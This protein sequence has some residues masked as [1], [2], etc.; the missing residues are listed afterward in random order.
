MP[1][2]RHSPFIATLL[3]AATTVL[4]AP[5][6][7]AAQQRAPEASLPV[8]P[9]PLDP[10]IY[11]IIDA[12]S[13]QRLEADIRRLA[14]FGTRS[15]YSDTLSET[16]GI[17]AA[18]RW[19]KAEFDRISAECGGCLEVRYVSHTQTQGAPQPTEIVNVIAIQRGTTHPNRYV[20]MSGDIDSRA[21]DGRDGE[22]DAPGANDNA[23]GM[24]GAIEAARLLSKYQF[25]SSIVYAGLSGEE[26]GLWGGRRLAE[27]AT[28]EGWDIV[29]VLNNDMIGNTAGID[30]NVDNGTF[31]VFSEGPTPRLSEQELGSMRVYGGE[32][33]G[34]SRQLARYVSRIADTYFPNLD[35]LMI[36]RLDRFG[37]GGHHRPF[38]DAGFPGVRIMETHEHYDR[39][40]QNLR[41]EDGRHFGDTVEYVDFDYAATMSALNA[42]V[43]ASIAWAPP[44]PTDVQIGGAVSAHT[45]LAWQRVPDLNLAGYRIYW[46]R[47]DAPQWDHS[48][49]VGDVTEYT[50]R[51]VVIDNWFFGVA[52]VGRNGNESPVVFPGSVMRRR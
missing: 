18:R 45:T 34:P 50:L 48:I 4:L 52:A 12:A 2:T 23:S 28:E 22:S 29:G 31:R 35:A 8:P 51:N 6:P 44:A 41:N 26:Q 33:D 5:P 49:F 46:R 25:A 42:A 32:V 21:S 40:H 47:T 15:T 11:D 3:F 10:R 14:G 24:A 36:Y 1:E 30:G 20:I 43:L 38:N 7:A 9:P 37:R 19:I 16:R 17:G 39:Q 13:P 27:V